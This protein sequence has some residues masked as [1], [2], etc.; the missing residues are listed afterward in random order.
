[1]AILDFLTRKTRFAAAL[2]AIKE[3]EGQCNRP[4]VILDAG[5]G[6]NTI[7]PLLEK[8]GHRVIVCDHTVVYGNADVVCDLEEGLP[9]EDSSFDVVVSLAVVEHLNNWAHALT[10]F[11]R[12]GKHVILTTPSAP[13]ESF[14]RLL[15]SLRLIHSMTG[16]HKCCLSRKKLEFFGFRVKPFLFGLNQLA[17][18]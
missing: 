13:G 9:F 17:T 2:G 4:L 14:L 6:L 16:E 1:M 7:A 8:R 12:V 18:I 10:E 5:G 15:L 3:I 11:R